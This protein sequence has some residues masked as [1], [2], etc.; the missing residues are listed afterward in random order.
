MDTTCRQKLGI[1]SVKESFSLVIMTTRNDITP[2]QVIQRIEALIATAM[3]ELDEEVVPVLRPLRNEDDIEDEERDD[4]NDGDQP[5]QDTA[6]NNQHPKVL[7][8]SLLKHNQDRSYTSI[9]LVL[10]FCHNLLL[11]RRTTTTRE[12]YYYYVTHFRSQKECDMAITETATLLQVSRHDL[13]LKA[14]PRGWF[15]GDVQLIRRR[16]GEER[17]NSENH[18]PKIILD[19]RVPQSIHGSPISSEW[20]APAHMRNFT[21]QTTN[22][23]CILVIE[24]EG[25][26]NRLLEDAFFERHPCILVTG[27]GFP[28][29]ATRAMVHTLHCE[30]ELPVWGLADCNPYGILVLHTYVHGRG[31]GRSVDGGDRYSV[32]MQWLG[33]RPSQIAYLQSKTSKSSNKKRNDPTLPDAVFQQM[34]DRDF[35][36]LEK[37]LLSYDK[38]HRWTDFG[39]NQ[40]RLQELEDMFEAGAKVELE[41]L[42]WL[43]MDYI[44][45]WLGNIFD[46]YYQQCQ[47]SGGKSR[48][49]GDSQDEL[50]FNII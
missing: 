18:H 15:C 28:D 11:S 7:A 6:L 37:S 20:L 8:K 12:V 38:P 31:G 23:V 36:L 1:A 22:A 45:G 13:G 24:K 44:G 29:L 33:L 48:L 32:P 19:G 9:L 42:N 14:S 50:C 27:K 47:D 40:E 5:S 35:S 39:R 26:Y 2:E 34:T 17:D 49:E 16:S 21:V 25:V 41:A 3:E 30:L 46:K 4:N 10:S 43:G